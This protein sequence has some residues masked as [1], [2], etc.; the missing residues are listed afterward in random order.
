MRQRD[1]GALLD[2][3]EQIRLIEEFLVGVTHEAFLSDGIRQSAVTYRV[4]IIGE[5]ATRLS[6]DFRLT[7]PEVPWKKIRDMRNF[8]LHVYDKI[9][10]EQV[11]ATAQDDLPPLQQA[12]Q[13]MLAADVSE[14]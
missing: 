4:A 5:A 2:I 3:L 7:H 13:A 10:F 11:W 6:D 1:R 9:D 12:V 14:D 8:L